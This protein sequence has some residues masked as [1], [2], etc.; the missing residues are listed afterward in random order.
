MLHHTKN[1]NS[2]I[3]DLLTFYENTNKKKYISLSPVGEIQ[4]GFFT[5]IS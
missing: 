4:R 3:M 5:S 1:A 2:G